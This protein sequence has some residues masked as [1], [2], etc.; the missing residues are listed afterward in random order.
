MFL[1]HF[2]VFQFKVIVSMKKITKS[3]VFTLVLDLV[4]LPDQL[5]LIGNLQE[6]IMQKCN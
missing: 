4:Q 3:L 2:S 1:F 5:N 6:F